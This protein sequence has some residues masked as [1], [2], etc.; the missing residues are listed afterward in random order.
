MSVLESAQALAF[1]L[2]VVFLSYILVILVPFLRRK[3]DPEGDPDSFSWHV[4]IPC[5]D[6]K[7]GIGETLGLPRRKFPQAHV[8]VVDDDSDDATADIVDAASERDAMIHL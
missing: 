2:L 6:E 5:R 1:V 8:W 4:F 7:V 3:P